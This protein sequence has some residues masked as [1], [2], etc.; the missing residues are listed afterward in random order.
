[1]HHIKASNL[2]AWLEVLKCHRDEEKTAKHTASDR[3][4]L[5]PVAEDSCW[6]LLWGCSPFHTRPTQGVRFILNEATGQRSV[7]DTV[8]DTVGVKS[9]GRSR[10]DSMPPKEESR[11]KKASPLPW[12]SQDDGR[13]VR[14]KGKCNRGNC[15]TEQKWWILYFILTLK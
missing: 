2:T 15:S 4:N 10:Q 6:C 5:V 9:R 13:G 1:M 8:K 7:K 12:A 14:E 3:F 11:G